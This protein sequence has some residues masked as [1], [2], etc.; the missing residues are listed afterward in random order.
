MPAPSSRPTR[1]PDM[2]FSGRRKAIFVHGCVW[3]Q[4]VGCSRMRV[5]E[6]RTR[7][8]KAKLGANNARDRGVISELQRLG[9]KV[10]VV[11]EC[12]LEDV[13]RVRVRIVNFLGERK[14]TRLRDGES[15]ARLSVN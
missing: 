5:P 10:L 3:H 6:S 15:L 1:N 14:A 13:R 8:W 12:E 7:F 11:W 9:W 4:H 2:V